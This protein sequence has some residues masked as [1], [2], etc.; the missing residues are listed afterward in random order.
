M[1]TTIILAAADAGSYSVGFESLSPALRERLILVGI[2]FLVAVA[3]IAGLLV[4]RRLK[5]RRSERRDYHQRGHSSHRA[6]RGLTEIKK[7]IR[8]K[9]RHRHREHGR[10]NP[11][12]AEVGG[13]PPLRSGTSHDASQDDSQLQ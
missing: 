5:R 8:R 10:Q 12:L 3:V 6:A 1:K 9:R 13:L 7:I 11:T 2:I 4:G